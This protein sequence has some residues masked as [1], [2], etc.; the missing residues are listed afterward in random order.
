MNCSAA[1]QL[2][3]LPSQAAVNRTRSEPAFSRRAQKTADWT[4]TD[5]LSKWQHRMKAV[6]HFA[7]IFAVCLPLLAPAMACSLPGARMTPSEMACCKHMAAEC[8]SAAMPVTHGCCH[9]D[10]PVLGHFN[11]VPTN[12]THLAITANAGASE[13]APAVQLVSLNPS[14]AQRLE[15]SPPQSPP[16]AI[17]VLRI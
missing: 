12:G 3:Q 11:G 17:S 9:K 13:V 1:R 4:R 10:L 2:Q 6:R 5:V 8:G 16:A 15:A 14:F 7:L